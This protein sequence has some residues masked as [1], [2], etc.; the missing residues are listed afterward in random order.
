MI[1]NNLAFIL[2][3]FEGAKVH[4]SL[5]CIEKKGNFARF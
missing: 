3:S 4:K 1:Y 5:K 2:C